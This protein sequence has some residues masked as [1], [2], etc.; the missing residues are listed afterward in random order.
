MDRESIPEATPEQIEDT[1]RG[2]VGNARE[3]LREL[4]RMLLLSKLREMKDPSLPEPKADA[5]TRGEGR[6]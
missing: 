5:P 4:K 3:E 2:A 6:K 1:T